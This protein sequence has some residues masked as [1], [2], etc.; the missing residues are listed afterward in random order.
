MKPVTI[1]NLRLM[2]AMAGAFSF[3]LYPAI[4]HAEVPENPEFSPDLENPSPDLSIKRE[5]LNI[6][7]F[8]LEK[9]IR[10]LGRTTELTTQLTQDEIENPSPAPEALNI[11]TSPVEKGVRGLGRTTQ[12]NEVQE[13]T[14]TSN[15]PTNAISPFQPAD[16]PLPRGLSRLAEPAPTTPKEIPTFQP[17]TDTPIP[18]SL[19]KLVAETDKGN[20]RRENTPTTATG[21]KI[22]TPS[23][24]G[25]IDVPA[26][27]VAVQFPS[28]SQVELR[29][30]GVLVDSSLL[31]RTETDADTNLVTQ[32]WYGVGLKEGENTL[33]AQIV[34]GTE[35]PV[36]L[37]VVVRGTA[38][39]LTVETVESRVPADGRS[40]ATI[41]GQ[42]LD[43]NG[44]R[45]NQDAIITLI[46]T[47]GE[48]VGTDLKPEQPG[49]QVEAKKGE[50]TAVW[51]S[52]L[53]AQTGR[54]RAVANDLEAFTQLEF[55]TA[56]RPS[57]V[58]GVIDVRLGARGTNYYSRF[59]DFLPSDRNNGTQLEFNSAIFATGAIGEWLFT[60]AYNSSR[61]LNED[62]NCDNR[63]FRSYQFSEQNYPVYGDSSKVDVVTPSIDSVYLRFERSTGIPGTAPDYAMWGD[64]NT[65]EFARSSQQFTAVTRQLHG[66]KANY[67]LGNLQ[68][69]GF[70]GN[71]LEAFQRDTIAP[72][73]T[74][75]YYFLSR[76]L[77][78]PGSENL[79]I[80]L[81][82]LN[83]PGTVLERKQ[84]SRGPDYEIDYD[85]GTVIFREPV[86][87]TDIDATGQVLVRRIVVTYQYDSNNSDSNIYA[88]RLQ[89]NFSRTLNQESW[90][91]ATYVRENQ[92]LRGF[93]LYGADAKI[94]LG[95]Q[96]Q[97]IAEYAHSRNDSD[98]MGRVRG[99]AYRLEAQGQIFSGLQ[100]RAYYRYADTGFANNATI[101]FVP[102]QTRY[103]GQLTGRLSQTTNIRVQY[104]HEDN[105]GIA[106]QPLDTFE[107]LFSP[108][109]QAIPG[110][111]VDNSL[112]TISAG[113]QQRFGK[114]TVDV[115][116]IHRNREDRI[117]TNGLES[118]SNQLRSRLTYPLTNNLTFQAQNELTLSSQKDTVY[119]DRTIFGLNWAVVP[120]VNIS[121]AQQFY[122]S[123]QSYSNSITSL[124]VNGEHKLGSDTT[125]TG[126]YSIIGGANELTTQGAI[127]LNNRW[128]IASGLRL[129]LAYEHVFGNFFNRTAAGQQFAQPFAVGQ[130]ASSIGFNG[131]DS[132]SIGLEYSDNPQ[133][134][135]SA[136]YEHRTSSGGSNTVITAAALGKISPALTALV[137]YQQANSSNQKL[138][139]LGDT[140]N[141]KLG[142]AYRDPNND[143]FNALLRYEYRQNPAT[144]PDTI[145][146][147]SGTGSQDHTFAV[148][149]IYAPNWQ[150]EF[151]G[152]YALRNSTS[153]LAN[154][155]VGTSTVNL[156]QLRATYRLGYSWDLVG[157]ARVIGQANYTETGFVVEAGYYLSPNLRL[158]AGYAFGKVDDQD[159]S[160]T[161]SAG[162]LYLGLTLKLNELFDGFGLQKPVTAAKK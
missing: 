135:A 13:E 65:E 103:G 112:T 42:L 144:I 45:S 160:G 10:G 21:V 66:F 156:G 100:G 85:R 150:W 110:S 153:Y 114:A 87:R 40:T 93:E 58:T 89:Y 137:R 146:L 124:S 132:Y 26:T 127:G 30:N 18:R 119:P 52:P 47:V 128:L 28:G 152:K 158:S 134:Q 116:W 32:T 130:S 20:G 140:A 145:L 126:R 157:E 98:I 104:D 16:D 121:L 49:F 88:G 27:T 138:S 74:S 117:A 83:R 123:G 94:S 102:G 106:P 91:A 122:S 159:F 111:Q 107:E 97:L 63:L 3:V 148:E 41:R 64:Y 34:G 95:S 23:P 2:G 70:Y 31:G 109:S 133:F 61:S 99:E 17:A 81:E 162:G 22:L 73:G 79:F 149:A 75:G 161:R 9:E 14:P 82:E 71:N 154:D 155:L 76:R 55:A 120:G 48:L 143:K 129:N 92:G 101:S 59:R 29:V 1:F 37:R 72:D 24:D 11:S 69:T 86:L 33:A 80:E 57:L 108:R 105:F 12:T 60:G 151:Y 147:G 15:A 7:L 141:L 56:L 4:V 77:V 36:T 6:P 96:N 54:I 118:T 62:C 67:N 25:V 142:L 50:F 136:R 131:G 90:I 78:V 39:K 19:R 43:E 115:D 68:I 113:I 51:R 44:N 139:G 125:L 53:Q 84:L 5:A 35:A 46:P 8:P 38:K